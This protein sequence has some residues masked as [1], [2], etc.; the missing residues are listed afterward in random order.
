[1]FACVELRDACAVERGHR[2]WKT[3]IG[4]VCMALNRRGAAVALL[5][6]LLAAVGL[7]LVWMAALAGLT[8][9]ARVSD[10]L[11]MV[12]NQVMKLAAIAMGAFV[13]IGRGGERGFFTGMALAIIYMALGYALYVGLGGN[14]FSVQAMLGEILIG[15]AFG[16]I[17][18]AVLANMKPI[19][20]RRA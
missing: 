7:T 14:A 18:G 16:A 20:T 10:G 6:G 1:M 11:I 12:L 13:A 2:L 19:R 15:A 17:I 9:L 5:K 4:V 8:A 3:E